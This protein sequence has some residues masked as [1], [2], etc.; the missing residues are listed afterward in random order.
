MARTKQ[1]DFLIVGAGLFGCTMAYE[2]NKAGFKCLVIDRLL[3]VGG[4]CYTYN[5]SGV[6][7]HKYGPHIFHTHDKYIWDY[8]NQFADFNHYVNSPIANYKGEL[9]NLPFNMNTFWQIH[10]FRTPKEV[11]AFLATTHRYDE[12]QNLEE[13]AINLVGQEVYE[14]LI[15]GYTEK[16]WLRP[17]TELSPS[18]IKRLP[19]R[20]TYDNN[21]FNDRYQG[22]PIGGYTQI[23]DKM[24]HGIHLLLGADFNNG[25]DNVADRIIWTGSVDEYFSYELGQLDYMGRTFESEVLNERNYQGV[26][27]MNYTDL[28]VPYLRTIE[29]KHF[30]F[31]Q[32]QKTVVTKEYSKKSDTPFDRSYPVDDRKNLELYDRY[33]QKMKEVD[34]VIPCGRLGSYKYYDMDDTIMAAMGLVNK[35]QKS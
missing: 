16:Q 9:Y 15:K 33:I 28:D 18:I 30:D 31:G 23:F 22:I 19:V 8:I 35:L 4:N 25:F 26:A 29:H 7:I 21:Y 17:C 10:G 32:Q 14:K 24:L 27:V 2:L 1:Y 20:L 5:S 6:N 12:P 11:E 34:H 3:H 13:Q